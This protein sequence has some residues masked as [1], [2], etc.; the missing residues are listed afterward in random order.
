MFYL[1]YALGPPKQISC[2]RISLQNVKHI[3]VGD[4]MGRRVSPERGV[5]DVLVMNIL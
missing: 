3:S 1:Q 4:E 5:L 2:V